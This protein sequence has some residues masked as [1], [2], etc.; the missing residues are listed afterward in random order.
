MLYDYKCDKCNHEILDVY[1]SI[2][3]DTLVNCPACG[4]DSLARVIYGGIHAS[5]R[6]TNTIGQLADKNWRSM[7]KYKQSEIL[8]KTKNAKEKSSTQELGPAT[9]KQIN[10]MSQQ[11]KKNYIITGEL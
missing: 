2:K 9:T 3:D 1:Q 4:K 6:G 8:E 5:V 11:Q 10:K 7:G